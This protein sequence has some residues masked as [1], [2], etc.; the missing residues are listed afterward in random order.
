MN[1]AKIVLIFIFLLSF[2]LFAETVSVKYRNS[3]VDISNGNFKELSIKPSTIVKRLIFDKQNSYLLV[4]LGDTFYHY[5]GIKE[6]DV[7][8]WVNASSLGTYYRSNIKGN[9]DCRIIL[10]PDY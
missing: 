4:K 10:P 9:F 5:C 8:A 6:Q 7:N 1:H 3:P 2:N